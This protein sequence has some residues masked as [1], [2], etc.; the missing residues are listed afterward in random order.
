MWHTCNNC[1]KTLSSYHSLWRH[2]KTCQLKVPS[3][4]T[5]RSESSSGLPLSMLNIA[6][7]VNHTPEIQNISTSEF[8]EKL[9]R[10]SQDAD[11]DDESDTDSGDLSSEEKT[12]YEPD[13]SNQSEDDSNCSD[14]IW[15]KLVIMSC[16]NNRWSSLD[17]FKTYIR[18]Y[19]DSKRNPLFKSIMNDVADGELHE[20]S[21]QKAIQ[22]AVKKNEKSIINNVKNCS[23]KEEDND[24]WFWCRLVELGKDLDCQWL[25]GKPCYCTKH[26]GTSMLNTIC[27]FVKLFIDMEK[28]DL[29]KEI[30]SGIENKSTEIS[31]NDAIDQ[32]VTD[33]KDEIILAFR[34]ARKK[35]DACGI[36]NRNIFLQ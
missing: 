14:W 26:Y 13:D 34:E 2:R 8:K 3:T 36:W 22:F 7:D 12:V 6:D 18:F 25:N 28:D 21:L 29:I 30:E 19:I 15:E 23:D 27:F 9:H 33:R 4:G 32:V 20:Q 35:V 24:N 16:H 1:G 11:G 10:K 31:L 5:R 17:L